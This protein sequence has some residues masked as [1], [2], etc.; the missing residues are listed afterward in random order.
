MNSLKRSKTQF[1][2][3]EIANRLSKSA[4][5]ATFFFFIIGLALLI[6]FG[7]L[8]LI[9][10]G[11]I[12]LIALSAFGYLASALLDGMA[13]IVEAKYYEVMM[14]KGGRRTQREEY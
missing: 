3:S 14:Y 4:T 1:Y 11:F 12:L 13:M 6:Y 8:E 9:V 10:I 2:K 7:S 5:F